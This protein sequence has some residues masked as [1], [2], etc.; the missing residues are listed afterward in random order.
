MILLV[1]L[2]IGA[3][4]WWKSQG[5]VLAVSLDE[6]AA[7]KVRRALGEFVQRGDLRVGTREVDVDV[8]I[9]RASRVKVDIWGEA[10][11]TEIPLGRTQTRVIVE[12]NKVQYM[13]PL[14]DPEL[15]RVQVVPEAALVMLWLPRPVVDREVVE[16]NSAPE[17]IRV[18][19]DKDWF[20]H[21]RWGDEREAAMALLREQVVAEASTPLA[22]DDATAKAA[23]SVQRMLEPIAKE[24]LGAKAEVVVRWAD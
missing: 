24:A 17:A 3:W 7:T 5:P 14:A 1:V 20:H 9:E 21:V 18:E 6:Q 23:Q 22:M 13:I 11:D 8:V 10:F 19:V 16:V 4:L 15:V 2:G 12:G